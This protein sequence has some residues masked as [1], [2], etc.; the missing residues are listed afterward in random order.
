MKSKREKAK[1]KGE[2]R[3][4]NKAVGGILLFTSL[5]ILTFISCD[6]FSGDTDND[7][8]KKIDAEIAWA[9]A[10][11]LTETRLG[12]DPLWLN[13]SNP[14]VGRITTIDIRKGFPFTVECEPAANYGFEEW[15]AFYTDVYDSLDKTLSANAVRSHALNGA[16]VDIEES[17]DGLR[18]TVTIH[19]G[20]RPVSIVPW[21]SPRPRLDRNTNPPVTPIQAS[22]PYDQIVMLWFNMPI[23]EESVADNI[24]IE[25]R[26]TT[27]DQ[28]LAGDDGDITSWFRIEIPAGYDNRV[29]LVPVDDGGIS[30]ARLALLGITVYVGGGIESTSGYVM[31]E[32]MVISYTTGT[33]R[34]QRAYR[35]GVIEAGR[36]ERDTDGNWR[37]AYFQ[38][39]GTQWNNPDIDRRFNPDN[40]VEKLDTVQLRFIVTPPQDS[41]NTTP[42]RI[43]VKELRSYNLRG[44][45]LPSSPDNEKEKTYTYTENTS[46]IAL[47][48]DV[49]T[50]NHDL[51]TDTSG[52]VQLLIL[53]WYDDADNGVPA[54]DEGNALAEG[55][56]VTI[57]VDM[58]A[59]YLQTA[60][61]RAG[62]NVTPSGGSLYVYS[63]GDEA[64][65]TLNG[66]ADLSDNGLL[67]DGGIPASRAW[68]L[69][70]TMDDP[71]ALLWYAKIEKDGEDDVKFSGGPL[72]VYNGG[73][74]NNTWGPIT[75]SDELTAG[76]Q[77]AV[78]IKFEDSLGNVSGWIET[79]LSVMYSTE[80]RLPVENLFAECDED[81]GTITIKWNTP[82]LMA[83]AYVY[84]NDVLV[85]V[86]GKG[87]KEH[88]FSVSPIS[89]DNVRAGTAVGN[90]VRRDIKVVAYN[91]LDS[92]AP[93]KE[94]SIWNIP[95]MYV[96]SEK[97]TATINEQLEMNNEQIRELRELFEDDEINN[98]V[99]TSNIT[100]ENWQP[101]N[102]TDKN[103]YG[104]GH[105]VT[106]KSF[107]VD[108]SGKV[109]AAD[110]GLFGVVSDALIR[111]LTVLY[112]KT[113]NID[114]A[115][116][117]EPEGTARFGGITGTAQGNTELLNVLVKGAVT[118]EADNAD[119]FVG[120][121][122]G[123]LGNSI[124]CTASITNA[125]GGLELT[126]Y[127]DGEGN[128]LFVGG[129][130]GLMGQRAL[131]QPANR[132]VSDGSAVKVQYSSA[133]GNITV[134]SI[135]RTVNVTSG[136]MT[137]L[138]VGGVVGL[139]NGIGVIYIKHA[140]LDDV[141]YR[142]GKI[143][144]T[145][146]SGAVAAGGT[147]G[148]SYRAAQ[149][150]NSIAL[151]S[152]IELDKKYTGGASTYTY[153]GGF[154]GD[155]YDDEI[156]TV[157]YCYSKGLVILKEI[158]IV[159]ETRYAG[160]FAGRVG[161]NTLFCYV[162]G[163]VEVY[164]KG[165]S[166]NAGGF[167]GMANL[168]ENCYATGN[169]TVDSAGIINA[170]GLVGDG[171]EIIN[172]F[173]LGSVFSHCRE[174]TK[175]N[176]VGGLIGNIINKNITNSAALGA[177]VTAT[178]GLNRYVGRIFGKEDATYTDVHANNR[179]FDG[180]RVYSDDYDE[181]EDPAQLNI[182]SA[183]VPVLDGNL[184]FSN[185]DFITTPLAIRSIT[186]FTL[187]DPGGSGISGVSMSTTLSTGAETGSPVWEGGISSGKITGIDLSKL[188]ADNDFF[189]FTFTIMTNA[190]S[191]SEY[192]LDVTRNNATDF[193]IGL[194]TLTDS[195]PTT[196]KT[197]NN[198]HGHDASDSEFHRTDIWQ[199]AA[200]ASG[201]PPSTSHGMEFNPDYW[202]FSTVGPYGYPVLRASPNGPIMGG[203]L[204]Q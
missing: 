183:P 119:T 138:N 94:L 196:E 171:D 147:V 88:T 98:I 129:I 181:K 31:D 187:D 37:I 36:N 115:V 46:E 56:Y 11:K 121:L 61:M 154:I 177:S 137:G 45:V 43:T 76:E 34:T 202:D 1:S 123:Q 77:Y 142:A 106:I 149:I 6:L 111:D 165:S 143:N 47:V 178:G 18:A 78:Y 23:K 85:T 12:A 57:V 33:G 199:K 4:V 54:L 170:G 185:T 136:D 152:S 200:P 74:L 7:L 25:G 186:G 164:G 59:P 133:V 80:E 189:Q 124:D 71:A 64:V 140:V 38:D 50:I 109:D 16:G 79:G 122:V 188:A 21:C 127:K 81:G 167:T 92:E 22:Y 75:P 201:F 151:H 139:I 32:T 198:L 191:W 112:E 120:G 83:G 102:F 49:F 86:D 166:I 26:H 55:H 162:T 105:T 128:S 58:A 192:Q 180:M 203:Q 197:H 173:A 42:N 67:T 87:P 100:L 153:M 193:E 89:K 97:G 19:T 24:R 14:P 82:T 3:K 103:F 9:N 130:A 39:P 52:I 66:L 41:V 144:I 70:W 73:S 146:G 190:G 135:G 93:P 60:D 126:V 145:G 169:V 204:L 10:A 95:G 68:S 2:E 53:P 27:G 5:L 48:D 29:N 195:S 107:A 158:D 182:T 141:D 117:I 28:Q 155:M 132:Y 96:E 194:L 30:A 160:G 51:L 8:L 161:E 114:D 40:P 175:D 184:E 63:L 157:K 172:S 20:E 84:V 72:T 159:N 90:V 35:P 168:I 69:P 99:L 110:I 125:Y 113:A 91:S 15:L 176:H 179:A 108:S 156:S 62:M 174:T 65:L 13:S 131:I 134:G 118:V 44:G 17:A 150:T 116:D 163:D 104:N 148:K 101:V